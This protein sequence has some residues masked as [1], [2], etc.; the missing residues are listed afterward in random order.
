MALKDWKRVRDG[1]YVNKKRHGTL[2]I[3]KSFNGNYYVSI[4]IDT[5]KIGRINLSKTHIYEE[6]KTK[7]KAIAY[8]K[9]YMRSH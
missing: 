4:E 3:G 6:F 9:S 8:A 1:K 5:I 7:P 2:F